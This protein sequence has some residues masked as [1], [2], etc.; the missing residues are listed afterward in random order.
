MA[1][2]NEDEREKKNFEERNEEKKDIA[3]QPE[4]APSAE[5]GPVEATIEKMEMVA[6]ES[7]PTPS[8]CA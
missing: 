3:P 8:A 1:N 6:E 7:A 4:P 2:R 5:A